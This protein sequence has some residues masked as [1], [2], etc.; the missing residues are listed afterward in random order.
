MDVPRK[1]SWEELV[2]LTANRNDWRQR[3]KNICYHN[4]VHIEYNKALPTGPKFDWDKRPTKTRHTPAVNERKLTAE[5]YRKHD[6]HEFLLRPSM[7]P[8][9][10]VC[11]KKNISEAVRM[12]E[13]VEN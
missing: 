2:Q 13:Q 6:A 8:K 5:R 11:S 12:N 10:A 3:V 1:Y 7:H 9:K 4:D